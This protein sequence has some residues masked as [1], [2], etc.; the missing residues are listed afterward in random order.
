[1]LAESG[2]NLDEEAAEML[3]WQQAYQAAAQAITV[4]D[5]LF[6]ALLSATRR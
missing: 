3:K 2:V 6:H 4:A 5:T 1:V